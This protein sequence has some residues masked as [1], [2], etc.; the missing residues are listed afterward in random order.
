MA[1]F[2]QFVDSVTPHVKTCPRPI[3]IDA[4]K[5][6]IMKFCEQSRVWVFDCS[7]IT[8]DEINNKYELDIPT[9]AAVCYVHSLNGRHQIHPCNANGMRRDPLLYHIQHPNVMVI[10]RKNLIADKKYNLVVSLMPR[11]DSLDCADILYD[12]Y[13]SPIVAG[14]VAMLQSQLGTTW[15]NAAMAAS[16]YALFTQGI[17]DAK[18]DMLDGFELASPDFRIKPQYF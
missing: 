8:T 16:Q 17:A 14:A 12:K 3:I 5:T 15:E 18:Q 6:V 1:E 11:Q 13:K 4:L 7:E 9:D 2:A 10:D